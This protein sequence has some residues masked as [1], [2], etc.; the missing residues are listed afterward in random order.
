MEKFRN[1]KLLLLLFLVCFTLT[2]TSCKNPVEEYGDTVIKTYKG[3][4]QFGKEVS[5]KQLQ[6]SIKAFHAAH[7]R[8]PKDL[9]EIR[10]FT[11][12]NLDGDKYDYDPS[13]GIIKLKK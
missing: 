3:T 11:G 2:F 12:L 6:E 4:Q 10:N 7:G 1:V 8:Y 9:E 5:L 13:L